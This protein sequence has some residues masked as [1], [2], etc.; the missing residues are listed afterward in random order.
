MF[1]FHRWILHSTTVPWKFH[2]RIH[3][4]QQSE[5]M[6]SLVKSHD[7]IT[8]IYADIQISQYN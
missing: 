4:A 2:E 6:H 7:A 3:R 8:N 1:G 5:S